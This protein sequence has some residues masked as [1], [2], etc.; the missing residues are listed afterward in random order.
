[1]LLSLTLS[2]YNSFPPVAQVLLCMDTQKN[3]TPSSTRQL[4]KNSSL[5]IFRV[6]TYN[7]VSCALNKGI[8]P[9]RVVWVENLMWGFPYLW[10]AAFL[11]LHKGY[12]WTS[13]GHGYYGTPISIFLDPITI[14]QH[15]VWIKPRFK[16]NPIYLKYQVVSSF[17][18][19]LLKSFCTMPHQP[20]WEI[21]G[22]T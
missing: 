22:I 5:A 1:M 3:S 17:N 8:W 13:K 19:K 15:L 2:L 18:L 21:S 10:T 9:C 4:I 12:I 6:A 14:F 16:P 11:F 7:C 20:G